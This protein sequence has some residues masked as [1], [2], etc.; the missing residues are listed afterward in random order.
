MNSDNGSVYK[1]LVI[2]GLAL[3]GIVLCIHRQGFKGKP[4]KMSVAF[5]L[6]GFFL[7]GIC[8][9]ILA[10]WASMNSG[11]CPQLSETTVLRSHKKAILWK[12]VQKSRETVGLTSFVSLHSKM[13]DSSR[14]HETIL[15][16][17]LCNFLCSPKESKSRIYSILVKCT[18]LHLPKWISWTI[19]LTELIVNSFA[20]TL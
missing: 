14:P 12:V 3:W 19:F 11:L 10:G 4:I 8:S 1:S 18:I 16:Y 6:C 20:S 9:G 5:S 13:T 2:L 15:S 7:S 17:I